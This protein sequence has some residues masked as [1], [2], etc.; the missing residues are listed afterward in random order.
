M[1]GPRALCLLTGTAAALCGAQL[2]DGSLALHM[3]GHGL[4]VAVGAPLVVLS[5]PITTLLRVLPRNDA[6]R[7]ALLLRSPAVRGLCW[8]PLAFAAFAA[9]QIAFHLTPLFDRALEDSALHEA[10]HAL[11]FGTAFWLWSVGLA[12]EPLPRTWPPLAR[13]ALLAAAMP[14]SDLGAVRLMLDGDLA[15]GAAM[16]VAMMPFG[17]AGAAIAW[18]GLLREERRQDRAQR[19]REREV[20]HAAG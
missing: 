16:V 6:R 20:A 7:L 8:P 9:V 12:V 10:E 13:A 2:S 18:R 11:F 5:R 19:R 3:L 14:V 4:I 1:S 17:L 15:A